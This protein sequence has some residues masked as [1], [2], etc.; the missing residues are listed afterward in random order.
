M[1]EGDGLRAA[2][3]AG[4]VQHKRNSLGLGRSRKTLLRGR[5]LERA[6]ILE[7]KGEAVDRVVPV[8]FSNGGVKVASSLNSRGVFLNGALGDKKQRGLEI[9]NVERKLGLFVVGVERGSN[10]GG[11]CDAEESNGKLNGVGDCD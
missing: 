5:L 1:R 3:G 8:D 4:S 2:G 7:V 10:E 9:L 6:D 11:E